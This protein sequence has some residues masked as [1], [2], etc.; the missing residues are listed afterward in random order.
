[1]CPMS[2]ESVRAERPRSF[3]EFCVLA[4]PRVCASLR[5]MTDG[6][7]DVEDVVQEALLIARHRWDEV[8]SYEYPEAWLVRVSLR[9]LV[10]W[11]TRDRSRITALDHDPADTDAAQALDHLERSHDLAAVIATLPTRQREVITLFYRLDLP[12]A[13]IAVALDMRP[14]TVRSL[15]ARGRATIAAR[16]SDDT[17]TSR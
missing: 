11:R 15:L 4:R 9:M 2:G 7:R 17:G 1:M 8:G 6:D 13:E 14:G 3:A 10:R 16:W 5:A 12:V